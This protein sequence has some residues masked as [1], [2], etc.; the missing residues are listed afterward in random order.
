MNRIAHPRKTARQAAYWGA[1][2]RTDVAEA[3]EAELAAA[4]RCVRCG[5]S[6][7]ASSSV[8]RSI[9]RIAREKP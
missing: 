9:A 1:H 6:L 7:S 2:G 5:R 8:E 3:L 4:E